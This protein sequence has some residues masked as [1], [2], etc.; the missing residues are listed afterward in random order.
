MNRITIESECRWDSD[1]HIGDKDVEYEFNIKLPPF[2]ANMSEEDFEA[3]AKAAL[4]YLKSKLRER[5]SWIGAMGQ[6]GRSGGWFFI[7]DR[8]GG[9]TKAKLRKIIEIVTSEKR[10]FVKQ[11]ERL[12]PR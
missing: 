11:M 9:A 2:K 7:Q 4:A 8:T 3:E 12:Y 1:Q 10:A 6:T 5:Y